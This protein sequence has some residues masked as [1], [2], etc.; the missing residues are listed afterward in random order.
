MVT[1]LSLYQLQRHADHHPYPTRRF[2]ALRHFDESPQLPSGYASM[3][4]LAYFP[5]PWFRQIDLLVAAHHEG[6]LTRANVLPSLRDRLM[7]RWSAIPDDW[8]CPQCA[9]RDKVDFRHLS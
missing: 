3:L 2:Q 1:S 5:P 4:L 7:A 6:D 8:A 9:V